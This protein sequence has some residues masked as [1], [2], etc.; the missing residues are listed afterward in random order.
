VGMLDDYPN[1]IIL[2]TFSKAY[3]LAGIRVGYMLASETFI[4][5]LYRILPPFP[6]GLPAMVIAEKALE[7][8]DVMERRI[9]YIVEERERVRKALGRLAYPSD[10]NFLLVNADAY[11]FLLE[12]GIVVRRLSGWLAGHIRVTVGRRLENNAFLEAIKEWIEGV[13]GI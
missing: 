13:G 5:A 10:A 12:R 7:Y 6:V 1:L 9:R 11:E 8:R 3:G 4:D 2:R